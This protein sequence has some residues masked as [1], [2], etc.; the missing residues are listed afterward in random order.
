MNRM[1]T[2]KNETGKVSGGNEEHA[3]AKQ[4]KGDSCYKVAKNWAELCSSDL[5]KVELV[6]DELGYLAKDIP[7][8][9][10]KGVACFFLAVQSKTMRGDKPK[11]EL[12]SNRESE[13]E[14]LENSQPIPTAI[15]Q[16]MCQ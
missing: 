12:L 4:R 14:D 8:Q 6:G 9:S 16:G 13:F 1:L 7:K 2:E 10:V 3:T 11:K 5:W 15:N